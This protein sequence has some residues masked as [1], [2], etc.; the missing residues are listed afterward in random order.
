MKQLNFI[1]DITLG[2]QINVL[3]VKTQ[4]RSEI[5]LKKQLFNNGNKDYFISSGFLHEL[6]FR[7]IKVIGPSEINCVQLRSHKNPHYGILKIPTK[8]IVE[9]NCIPI[10]NMCN[11]EEAKSGIYTIKYL[12]KLGIYT[13]EKDCESHNWDGSIAILSGEAKMVIDE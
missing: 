7:N 10:S 11:F 12:S 6:L 1:N 3:P 2:I 4:S 8:D 9:S 5:C 13:N